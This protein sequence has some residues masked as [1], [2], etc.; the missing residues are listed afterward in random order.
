M[1][2]RAVLRK[3]W[4][5]CETVCTDEAGTAGEAARR[6][7]E[8]REDGSAGIASWWREG[9]HGCAVRGGGGGWRKVLVV[10][11]AEEAVAW[12][13][14]H[15]G[16]GDKIAIRSGTEIVMVGCAT[17]DPCMWSH[18]R[19]G[20]C[21]KVRLRG[22]TGVVRLIVRDLS[23]MID[24]FYMQGCGLCPEC[25]DRIPM[26]YHAVPYPEPLSQSK[27]QERRALPLL[28]CPVA[29]PCLNAPKQAYRRATNP[30]KQSTLKNAIQ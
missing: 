22:V 13:D 15:I 29:A 21:I 19:Q 1:A 14:G 25:P 18:D 6:W 9:G 17:C 5:A 28:T 23:A 16:V 24:I 10:R 4:V 30:N 27:A 8:C 11:V 7:R 20:A 2:E 3:P 26:P 12:L